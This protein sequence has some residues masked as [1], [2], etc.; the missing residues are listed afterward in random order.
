MVTKVTH[1]GYLLSSKNAASTCIHQHH[2]C[3]ASSPDGDP[4]TVHPASP[5]THTHSAWVP[6]SP[7]PPCEA[8]RERPL[9]HFSLI[10]GETK[11]PAYFLVTHFL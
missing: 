1:G 8:Q 9:R 4:P 5:D 3:K 10:E 2:L 11:I 7:A 6:L